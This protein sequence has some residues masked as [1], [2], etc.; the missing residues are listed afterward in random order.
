MKVDAFREDLYYRLNVI[1]VDLP[2]L[3]ERFEDIPLL[4]YY[5]L[6]KHAERLKKNVDK[7]SVDAL[8]A[9][10]SYRWVGNIR[11][12]ENAIERAVVLSSEDS[13]SVRELPPQILG[14]A[15]YLPPEEHDSRD[16]TRF[17]YNDAKEKATA[18]FNRSYISSLLRLTSGNISIASQK[19]GMDRSNFK[20][21]IKKYQI[22]IRQ[23]KG[24]EE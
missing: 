12:L 15:F 24:E 21:I 22:D 6:K 1:T 17:P 18:A 13:I 4:A 5:F 3:R 20:K 16:L 19:A 11:E 7:I 10:Q 23:F 9:L 14:T 8:Q 2:P